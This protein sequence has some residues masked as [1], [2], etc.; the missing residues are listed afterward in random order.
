MSLDYNIFLEVAVIPLDIALFVYLL[1]RYTSPTKVNIAFRRF[2]C[3]VMITTIFDVITA[4][5]SS[6]HTLVPNPVHY[7]FNMTDS[8]LA[9]LSA[10]L[11]IYYIYA[12]CT[13]NQTAS[14]LRNLMNYTLLAVN[15][16][17]LLTN[18]ITGWVF[19]YDE[20]GNYI[21]EFL[22]IP[23]AYGFPILFFVIASIYMLRHH[24]MYKKS[25][26]ITMLLAILVAGTLFFLQMLYFDNVLITF[27][28][29]SIGVLVI[30]LSLETPE[31]L[32]LVQATAELNEAKTR[33]AILE[34][35]ERLSR[36]VML[37]LSKAVDAKDHYTN[38][39][40]SR[41]AEYAKE[42]AKRMGK[43]EKEQEEIYELG[44]LHDIGKIGVSEEII[45]KEGRLT[46][47]EFD[48]IKK[49]TL[50]GW[51]ILK[52]IT[53]IPWLSKGARWH[54]ERYDGNGYPDGLKG[55]EIPEEARIICLADS[56]D[57]MTSKRSYSVPKSQKEVRDEIVRCSGTQFDPDI[58]IYLLE[59]IDED[60][61]FKLHGNLT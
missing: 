17:L 29:A 20:A 6:S 33:E 12:Y 2:T 24:M 14:K 21:H 22:F 40:S 57:A 5:V 38:G 26:L 11:F 23:V 25:Q 28:I 48:E 41:V 46:D 8:A 44:L 32:R 49:H 31:Y 59:M 15:Y 27:F 4:I 3:A 16:L 43:S 60:T 55:K 56:Y 18:P 36:E 7:F 53:E 42:I 35:K 39:H 45:N 30:F 10:F 54:H 51:E 61:E 34:S 37:A 19:T 47:E 58:A 9:S 13:M 1:V 52:T 50:T